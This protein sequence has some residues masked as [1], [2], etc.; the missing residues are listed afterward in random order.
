MS[1]SDI[2]LRKLETLPAQPGVYVFY[3]KQRAVLYVGKARSLRSRVRSYFQPGSSDARAFVARLDNEL[4]DLET[5]ITSSEKEA[6]LL[7]NQLIKAH[8]PRYNV[9]LKD[10]KDFLSLRI[11]PAAPWPRID[12]V[13][14][15]R[16][17]GASYYG[18]YHSA[19]AARQTLRLVNRHFQ[20][21]TCSDA[22]LARRVRPC[23]QYQIKRC[24]APCVLDVPREA[25]LE[26]VRDVG[27]FLA[28]R[29]DELVKHLERRMAESARELDFEQAAVFRDQLRA[30]SR[31]QEEQRVTSVSGA[32]QDVVG[33]HRVADQAE[34]ALLRIREG[35]LV[36]V[37]T[38]GLRDV[39]LPDDELV[40]SFVSEFY[41]LPTTEFPDELLLPAAVEAMDGLGEMLTERREARV[42]VLHPQRGP[43]VRL[44]EMA[45]ENAEHAFTEKQ[46]ADQDVEKRLLAVQQ[47]LRLP[48]LPR[49]IEC[50]DISHH[51]GQDTVAA[52]VALLDGQPDRARY[53]SFHLQTV[54]G[55]DDYG[56][57]Y[58]VLSRRFKRA[59]SGDESWEL[60]DLL[61]VDGGRGQLRMALEALRD[62]G[63]EGLPL[64]GLA[65]E[66]ENVL[67]EKLVDRVYLPEQKNPIPLHAVAALQMLA[68]A[69]DEAHRSSNRIREQKGSHRRLQSELDSIPGVGASTRTKLLRALGS[70]S[71][72][73]AASPEQLLAAG[74]NK[75]QVEA[76]RAHATN[77]D[78]V[79]P[80]PTADSDGAL[81]PPSVEDGERTE[82]PPSVEDAELS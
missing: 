24:P 54:S 80:P 66:K 57:I 42:K 56:A 9:K 29:H 64:V 58:E 26:Q 71:S 75:R 27:L 23:L 47:K 60:P 34:V 45:R 36:N 46:R 69:R 40:A 62:L 65:K 19:T 10:D 38:F 59:L 39:S 53:R 18:P 22:E 15:P 79:A 74:A 1:L 50:I 67:G 63:M 6:A 43:R 81:V 4:I 12:V 28:G 31:I 41:A 25:Y 44:L 17:D 5:F 37:R 11:N 77:V 8:Q 33:L 16:K 51:G 32:D 13:R 48:T 73:L 14:K 68:L 3:G 52:V 2:V 70:V 76:I 82:A 61:V 78:Q 35:K 72:V 30:V 55:G 20:L 49:R 7:E 21:R